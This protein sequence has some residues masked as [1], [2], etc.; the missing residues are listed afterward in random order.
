MQIPSDE[1]YISINTDFLPAELK[2]SDLTA[3]VSSWQSGAIS[4]ETMFYNLQQGEI[5][6]ENTTFEEEEE[7]ISNEMLNLSNNDNPNFDDE[8]NDE[9]NMEEEEIVNG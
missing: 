9:D 5:I 7:A 4:K 2:G 8:V 6:P 1:A 3:L